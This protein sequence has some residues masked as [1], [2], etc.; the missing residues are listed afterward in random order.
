MN[1][2][3]RTQARLFPKEVRTDFLAVNLF[4]LEMQKIVHDSKDMSISKGKLDFWTETIEKVYSVASPGHPP[5]RTHF[6]PPP[7]R[8][9]AHQHSK[10]MLHNHTR[11][12]GGLTSTLKTRSNSRRPSKNSSTSSRQ[13]S[14]A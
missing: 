2:Y 1:T 4:Y 13:T 11:D 14:S 10:K 8:R 6:P 12:Q 7:G 3:L 5:F 9:Q